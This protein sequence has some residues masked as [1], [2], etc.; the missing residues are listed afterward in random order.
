MDQVYIRLPV[1]QTLRCQLRVTQFH[2]Q[3][4]LDFLIPQVKL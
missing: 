4:G 3:W 2:S 1:H